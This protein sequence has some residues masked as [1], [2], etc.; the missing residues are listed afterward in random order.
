MQILTTNNGG[1]TKKQIHRQCDRQSEIVLGSKQRECWTKGGQEVVDL[2]SCLP[3]ASL[4]A[5]TN[6]LN[7]TAGDVRWQGFGQAFLA[8]L[9]EV[10]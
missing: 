6:H 1:W 4:I 9:G 10:Y 5:N 3:I 8:R 2:N 7:Q